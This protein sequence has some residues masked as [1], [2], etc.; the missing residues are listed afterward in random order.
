M[1]YIDN[2]SIKFQDSSSIDAFGRLRVS[3]VETIFDSK[4]L[5]TSAVNFWDTSATFGTGT[6]A[7]YTSASSSTHLYVA[8][9]TAGTIVRQTFRRFNYQPG[10]SQLIF[11]T[12]TTSASGGGTGIKRRMGL[13]DDG[14]GIFF[15]DDQGTNKF[16]LRS[17][18]I[19]SVV[20][21]EIPQSQWNLDKL[22]G[23]GPSKKVLDISK[24]QI[25]VADIEWLGVG[26]IRVGFV[27]DGLIIYCH[28]YLNSNINKGVYMRTPNLPLR[29]EISN[30][31]TGVQS[32]LEHICGAVMSEGGTQPSG[33]VRSSSTA[34][35][36]VSLETENQLYAIKGIRI[37]PNRKSAQVDILQVSIFLQSLSD[38]IEWV[39][40]FNPTVVGS[41]TWSDVSNSVVQHFNGVTANT[42]SGGIE[43][44]QGYVSTG[45]AQTGRGGVDSL[46]NSI[47]SLGHRIDGTP[48][49][50]VLAARPIGGS[51][52]GVFVEGG[53]TWK[54]VV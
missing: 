8:G 29:Y 16:V 50:F 36:H 1:T 49:T 12:G 39:L 3:D 28:Q 4:Q 10:K 20:D 47:L 54:E 33:I 38:N 52:T 24:S 37:N 41:I 18:T 53:L 43:I 35:T 23:T 11:L 51:A 6:S 34:G 19:G 14:N 42:V 31:G 15:M 7:I 13:Y 32:S 46:I 25:M 30:N 17:D 2:V 27:I 9:S 22:D 26:R 45:N 44:D 21:N 40:L 48:Q 5:C